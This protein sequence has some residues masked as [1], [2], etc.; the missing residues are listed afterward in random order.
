MALKNSDTRKPA[1]PTAPKKKKVKKGD[2]EPSSAEPKTKGKAKAES[3]GP[4][5]KRQ[6]AA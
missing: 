1:G 6:K 3:S 4:R 2:A 5:S